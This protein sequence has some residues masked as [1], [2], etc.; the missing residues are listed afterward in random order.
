MK[1]VIYHRQSGKLW[2]LDGVVL[3]FVSYQEAFNQRAQLGA[4]WAIREA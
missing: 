1:Y 2:A 4:A 3:Q